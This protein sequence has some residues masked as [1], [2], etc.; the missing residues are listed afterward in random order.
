MFLVEGDS[1]HSSTYFVYIVTQDKYTL[2]L[3]KLQ[4]EKD[5]MLPSEFQ[6][7]YK[8]AFF[9]TDG[10]SRRMTKHALAIV[11]PGLGDEWWR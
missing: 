7:Q 9:E 6:Q 11:D 10:P 4:A 5:M 3:K 1:F 8:K 2:A